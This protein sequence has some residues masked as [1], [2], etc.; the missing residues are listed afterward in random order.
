MELENVEDIYPLSPV[1]TGMLFHTL[2]Q[3]DAGLY[4]D[5]YSC[6]LEGPLDGAA[7]R[8]AWGHL[9]RRH[10]VLRSAFLWEGLDEPMQVVRGEVALPW[11]EGDWGSLDGEALS[12]RVRACRAANRARG[13]EV[14]QAPLM[15]LAL[16]RTGAQT[17][18]FVWC[19]HHI[20]S[21]GWT[22]QLLLAEARQVYAMLRD[23]GPAT[24]PPAPPFHDYV[25]WLKAQDADAAADHWRRTLGDFA[26]TTPLPCQSD[27]PGG[28]AAPRRGR[29]DRQVGAGLADALGA[30][31]RRYRV[32]PSTL[33]HATWALILS[34]YAAR[35]DVV[36]GSTLS[37]RPPALPGIERMA[38]M[39]I[40]TLPVRV[41]V[42]G[43]AETSGWLADLHRRLVALG[44]YQHSSLVDVQGCS[45]VPRGRP[46][47]ESIVVFENL[48]VSHE[49]ASMPD[50]LRTRDAY[51]DDHSNY[52]L[53]FLALPGDG[54]RLIVIFDERRFARPAMDRLL[55]Q[56]QTVLAALAAGTA[57]RLDDLPM[58]GDAAQRKLPAQWQHTAQPLPDEGLLPALIAR[59]ASQRPRAT[60]VACGRRCLT[61]RQLERHANQMAHRLV[62]LGVR[63]D[64]PVGIIAD[65]A[66]ETVV[67][68]LAVLR[69]GGAYVPLDPAYPAERIEAVLADAAIPVLLLP[70]ASAARL[71]DHAARR[72]VIDL[73]AR[74]TGAPAAQGPAVAPCADDLAYVLYTS[75]STGRP[76]GV[77]VTHG[78]LR[79]STAAR[80]RYYRDPPRSFLLLSS[81][82][83]DSSVA[84]LF[85]TLSTGGTL[86]V[87]DR[88]EHADPGRLTALVGQQRVSH[89]LGIPA[90]YRQLLATDADA[91]GGLSTVIVA[92][93]VC[94]AE[95]VRAHQARLP[96]VRLF[97][98]YGPTEATVWCTVF[99][100]AELGERA[101]V[102]IGRAIANT[103]LYVLDAAGRP[104]PIGV[105]GELYIGGDGVAR[106]YLNQPAET[107][108][109]FVPDRFGPAPGGRLYRA[110]DLVRRLEN[111]DLEF[112]GRNDNQ[113][114]VRGHRIELEDIESTLGA[115]PD[116]REAVVVA[117]AGADAP[118]AD[119]LKAALAR[120]DDA[121]AGR[122]LA[123]V[124]D[125]AAAADPGDAAEHAPTALTR[126][127]PAFAFTLELHDEGFIRPP[128]AS[129]RHWLIDQLLNEFADD[130]RHLDGI[131]SRFVPGTDKEATPFDV[132]QAPLSSQQIMED[133]Q[134]P[135]MKAMA[136]RA[137][138]GHGDVLEV[139]FGRGVSATFIQERG[140]RSHTVVEANDHAIERHFDPWRSGLPGRDI[141]LVRGR[142]QDHVDAL[143]L[144]DG[145]FFHA[146]PLNEQEFIEHVLHGI[147][148][149]EH[150]FA[151][152]AEHLRPDG[153]FTYLSTEVDSLS[154]RHQRALLRHF[155]S[156]TV[157]VEP[158]RVP[159]DTE[160][161]WWADTMVIISA[162]R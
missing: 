66:V 95:L 45:A 52:A 8:A 5:Q 113:V 124:E 121:T 138:A 58:L 136:E 62:E 26:A 112:L 81:F 162:V 109:R 32:T 141:R 98:E 9:V 156:L 16:F 42:D 158:V 116:V 64:A 72:V 103:T 85:W 21:D 14:D 140:V 92:G 31:A 28:E 102:P 20:I 100:C 97:N 128:R 93:E 1:Q 29:R 131:A 39:M 10:P 145:I 126:R 27:V 117:R 83:F 73:D 127:D 132:T 110:G 38:G 161:T 149:A 61:Y 139:G 77:M 101:S 153:V 30:A 152:A 56:A 53:A 12:E 133:W 40:N 108:E 123:E 51:F 89:L 24:L 94:P 87:P 146:F 36:F 48:H 148:F 67:A 6:T 60:A 84:G 17:H 34:R 76:K 99:D 44:S 111:G 151:V 154:R 18:H 22:T 157:S 80:N 135:V 70:S 160:D 150:F 11:E 125:A 63:R 68:I 114:K 155:R 120:V 71:P 119:Q 13:F 69:A 65:R 118:S 159:P 129:Q 41:Q 134:T 79:H 25:T 59:A 43:A 57:K 143:G 107:A 91:L 4:V 78:N 54:L 105:P 106:G 144:Y 130:L 142:W 15:R 147:T 33:V 122:L 35:E 3:P 37:G 19:F 7:L 115:H 2:E 86:V 90:F 88:A 46:L 137:T 55:E 50:G 23:G 75:G 104:V 49:A 47:F 82:A 74:P 96:D